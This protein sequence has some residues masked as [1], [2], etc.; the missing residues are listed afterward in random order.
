MVIGPDVGLLN[1]PGVRRAGGQ[2]VYLNG[3]LRSLLPALLAWA[4]VEL[5][6]V[7]AYA[8]AGSKLGDGAA[9]WT[10]LAALLLG[11]KC[12]EGWW[13]GL[14]GRR[15]AK[16]DGKQLAVYGAF[17]RVR[18]RCGLNWQFEYDG[19]LCAIA[20]DGRSRRFSLVC[21]ANR[22]ALLEHLGQRSVPAKYGRIGSSGG[23]SG[24]KI[25]RSVIKSFGWRYLRRWHFLCWQRGRYYR[26][27]GFPSACCRWLGMRR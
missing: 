12:S 26:G 6:S 15:F 5:L 17:G 24:R 23:L 18:F 25:S 22:Y 21:C 4:I 1:E 19:G 2:T 9:K 14:T 13:F 27:S 7:L 10:G 8:L 16:V 3:W 11:L 20:P